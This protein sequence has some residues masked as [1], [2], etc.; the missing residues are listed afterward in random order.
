VVVGR[1]DG[2][3]QEKTDQVK[4]QHH[5]GHGAERMELAPLDLRSSPLSAA[6]TL[7]RL[8]RFCKPFAIRERRRG[9]FFPT[10]GG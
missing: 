5:G 4:P 1:H 7:S 8:D 6:A 3:Q 2:Q 10:G 9:R